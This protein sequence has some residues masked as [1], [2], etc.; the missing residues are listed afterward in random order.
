MLF[1]TSSD[2]SSPNWKLVP[3]MYLLPMKRQFN[4]SFYVILKLKHTKYG[5]ILF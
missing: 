3:I 5:I 4:R 2:L 1:L